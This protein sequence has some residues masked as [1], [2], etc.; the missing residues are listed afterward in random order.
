VLRDTC[1]LNRCTALL[2]HPLHAQ[3]IPKLPRANY[4]LQPISSDAGAFDLMVNCTAVP[5]PDTGLTCAAPGSDIISAGPAAWSG[6]VLEYV[7]GVA[8]YAA[9]AFLMALLVI[10][11]AFVCVC[12]RYILCC[13]KPTGS[14]GCFRCGGPEPTARTRCCGPVV[15]SADK[16][17]KDAKDRDVPFAYPAWEVAATRLLV[18]VFISFVV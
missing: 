15:V 9:V 1:A 8:L 16:R 10:G 4:R 12:G 7:E 2:T 3:V 11:T 18:F 5:A 13:C 17:K 6:T 14:C